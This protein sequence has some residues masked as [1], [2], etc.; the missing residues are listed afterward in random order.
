MKRICNAEHTH[1][2]HRDTNNSLNQITS[3]WKYHIDI[4]L[5]KMINQTNYFHATITQ[6]YN[7]HNAN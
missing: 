4:L 6:Y 3:N 5:L 2:Q 1:I 7:T